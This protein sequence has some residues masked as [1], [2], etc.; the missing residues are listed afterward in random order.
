MLLATSAALHFPYA[1][2]RFLDLTDDEFDAW[3]RSPRLGADV[4][5]EG[6]L[7]NR[8]LLISAVADPRRTKALLSRLTAGYDMAPIGDGTRQFFRWVREH[9]LLSE[10]CAPVRGLLADIVSRVGFSGQES[11]WLERLV[12]PARRTMPP[13]FMDDGT[14]FS[15]HEPEARWLAKDFERAEIVRVVARIIDRL[16]LLA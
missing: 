2:C 9:V 12:N 10:C 5:F 4:R 15:L 3:V 6:I 16:G 13:L 1:A 14:V 7:S 11:D 8:D